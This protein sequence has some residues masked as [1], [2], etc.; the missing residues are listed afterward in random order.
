M[1]PHILLSQLKAL[2][3]RAPDFR[4]YSPSSMEHHAWLGQAHALISRWNIIEAVSLKTAAD[5]LGFEAN[6][7]WNIG[8]IFG[9]LHR[10]ISDLELKLPTDAGQAFGPGAVYDFFKAL[11]E[12]LSSAQKSL[13]IADPFMDDTIFD[14]YLSSVPRGITV[15]LLVGRYTAK[16]KP[17]A[18]KF[19]A[20]YGALLEVRHSSMFHDRLIFLDG[21]VCWVIGQSIKDA[22]SA[23][24]TY[25]AP[26]SADVARP[27]LTGYEQIWHTATAI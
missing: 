21:D 26:L 18:D 13:F 5:F 12:L 15:R 23:K 20:Q 8:Q 17:A 25:L 27:K 19:V 4:T 11:N 10:A 14:T 1:D 24:P 22:A 6:R 3:V 16:I 9:T 2:L 7:Q